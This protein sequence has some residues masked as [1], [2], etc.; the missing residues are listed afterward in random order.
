MEFGRGD[1]FRRPGWLE[2]AGQSFRAPLANSRLKGP[3]KRIYE[4]V[5][6]Q[7]AGNR[8]VAHLP[9]GES[10]RLTA[11]NRQIAWNPEEYEAFR[12][13]VKP[14][15]TV[16]D[17]GANLGAYTVLL[18]QWV[19]ASG[20]V[21]AFEPAPSARAGL[22]RHLH[23]NGIRDRVVVHPEAVSDR[24]G[25]AR[26]RAVGMQG[27]NRLLGSDTTDGIDVTTTTID[28]FCSASAIRPSFIKLDVEGAEL[29]ALRGARSTIA[30]AGGAVGLFVEIHPH[31][32][33]AFGYSR[34][35]LE[36]EL[37]HQ[38][39]RL[40]RLDGQPDPWSLAGVTLRVRHCAS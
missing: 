31:L 5:L 33:P 23:L 7:F 11:A 36:A 20:R 1:D 12:R 19:G 6:D 40:E 4:S 3:L 25:T 15:A 37:Q 10:V 38:G 21:H 17:I 35:D 18:A 39:L 2:R 22:T 8:L 30:S 9:H 13:V 26:F 16:L 27:D 14:G 24:P 29:Q 28:E 34:A 32:W